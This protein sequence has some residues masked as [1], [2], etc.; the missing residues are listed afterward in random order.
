[1]RHR[2]HA[3]K[4]LHNFVKLSCELFEDGSALVPSAKFL[5]GHAACDVKDTQCAFLNQQTCHVAQR[6]DRFAKRHG[7][8][9]A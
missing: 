8:I 2:G 7:G 1:M 9:A 6:G 5:L 3:S 4:E